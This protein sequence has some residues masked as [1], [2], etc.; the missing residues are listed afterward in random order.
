M[1]V[2]A[3]L[4]DVPRTGWSNAV[5]AS[6]S[7][8]VETVMASLERSSARRDLRIC[9]LSY[10][11]REH[12]VEALQTVQAQSKPGDLFVFMFAGHGISTRSEIARKRRLSRRKLFGGWALTGYDRFDAGDLKAW[13]KVLKVRWVVISSCCYGLGI[14]GEPEPIED[15]QRKQP[16]SVRKIDLLHRFAD[17]SAESLH[18][19]APPERQTICIAAATDV[20]LVSSEGQR[21]LAILTA[22]GAD[23]K[24]SYG[25]LESSF[26]MVR[27]DGQSFVMRA[28]GALKHWRVLD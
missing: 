19:S 24:L 13:Y 28:S 20:E 15:E 1:T 6:A 5:A 21:L 17:S 27:A 4:I 25:D 12:V 23:L 2:F 16:Y 7:F 26:A 3:V 8:A 11:S 10:A 9:R 14:D 22:G 18:E